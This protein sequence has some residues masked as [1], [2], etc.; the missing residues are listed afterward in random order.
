[1]MGK[2]I[3]NQDD[4]LMMLDSQFR[5]VK[6][7]WDPFY[8]DRQRPVPFF[9][10]KPDENLNHYLSSGMINPGRALELGCGPG[11]NAIFL[12]LNGFEVD[13]VDLSEVAID[14][15]K[16]RANEL[17]L[18][19][20]FQCQ[21]VFELSPDHEY[22][23]IYDSGC[24]HHLLPHRRIQYMEMIHNGLKSGGHFGL[25]CFAPG[26]GDIGGPQFDMNDWEVYEEKSMKGGLAFT[27]EK[28]RYLLSDHFECIELRMME[29]MDQ[30]SDL[31][32]VPF[33]WTSLWRK[34]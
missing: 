22:D 16:E 34:K 7:F 11:R 4:L 19:I 12:K 1:M 2:T 33:L 26:F 29:T 28:I 17:L 24:M 32:G 8:S 25:T 18:D 10:N 15:A 3:K 20:N 14:W 23:L 13:A 5:S 30:E 27:E 6:E 31:F 9:H 21:S